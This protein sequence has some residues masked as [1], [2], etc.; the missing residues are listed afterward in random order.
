MDE[1]LLPPD[2]EDFDDLD[3]QEL[4]D[5]VGGLGAPLDETNS[6]CTV[7]GNCGCNA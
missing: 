5:V 6:G 4:E 1:G 3:V 2:E 7:N